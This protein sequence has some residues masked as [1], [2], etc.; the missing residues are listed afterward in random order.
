MSMLY[1]GEKPV[2]KRPIEIRKRNGSGKVDSLVQGELGSLNKV[3][4]NCVFEANQSVTNVAK[5]Q[6]GFWVE[7][8]ESHIFNL[9]NKQNRQ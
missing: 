4:N 5:V 6:G 2:K 8:V 3:E 9:S 1:L 7:K